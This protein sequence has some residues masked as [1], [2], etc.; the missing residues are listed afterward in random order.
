[1]RALDTNSAE[2]ELV[3]ELPAAPTS[4]LET[5][6]GELLVLM[7]NSAR[8]VSP[9]DPAKSV[10]LTRVSSPARARMPKLSSVVDPDGVSLL[11]SWIEQLAS[12]PSVLSA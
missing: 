7:Q 4:F 11:E 8:I 2:V 3:V 1:M 6:A 10:L 12:C 5:D 9:S